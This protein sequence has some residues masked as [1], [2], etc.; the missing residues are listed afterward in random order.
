[1][2]C[3][4]D[5]DPGDHGQRSAAENERQRIAQPVRHSGLLQ[6]ALQCPRRRTLNELNPLAARA[7]AD[8]D[9]VTGKRRARCRR[10]AWVRGELER[11][12]WEREPR[13]AA[14]WN[15]ERTDRG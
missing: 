5:A 15:L 6:D 14:P 13:L 10:I 12:V 11:A 7:G 1:M 9:V 4:R 2:E 8:H 3:E